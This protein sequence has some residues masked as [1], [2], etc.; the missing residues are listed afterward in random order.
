MAKKQPK[1]YTEAEMR[2][3]ANFWDPKTDANLDRWKDAL[4]GLALEQAAIKHAAEVKTTPDSPYIRKWKSQ[5]R[6][7][8]S[9]YWGY[10]QMKFD[11]LVSFAA[12]ADIPHQ[13][14]C[15]SLANACL[16]EKRKDWEEAE[17]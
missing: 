14:A 11:A 15:D 2:S 9:N 7:E 1:S 8:I 17:E 6:P 4:E 3:L 13:E 12:R 16:P 10:P 5:Y